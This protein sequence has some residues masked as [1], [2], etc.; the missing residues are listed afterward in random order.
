MRIV[1][2]SMAAEAVAWHARQ[3]HELGHELAG[4]LTMK[5]KRL[6]DSVTDVIAGTPAGIDTVVVGAPERVAPLLHSYEPDVALCAGFGWKLDSAALAAPR[7]GIVNGHPS[8][9]P[10]WRGPNPFGW[11]LRCGENELGFTFHLMDEGFDTGPILAQGSVPLTDEDSMGSLFAR[12]PALVAGLLPPALERIEAG[13]RGDPQNE[14]EASYAPVYE[15]EYAEI[16][17]ARPARDVHNQARCWFVPTVSGI[18]GPLTT[19]DGER[20][21]VLETR[22]VDAEAQAAPGTILERGGDGLL[23]ACGDRPIRV[24]RTEPAENT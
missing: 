9:L 8:L 3:L 2:V 17:W 19:L 7:L 10:R 20:V 22:L 12:L 15:D 14:E 1:I 11:T 21:R 23:V 24:L 4:V 5:N 16:D 13:D 6:P 18:M